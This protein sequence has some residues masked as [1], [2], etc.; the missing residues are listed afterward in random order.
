MPFLI[1]SRIVPASGLV[2][3]AV[4]SAVYRPGEPREFVLEPGDALI[5]YTD[6]LIGK[7][8]TTATFAGMFQADKGPTHSS[9]NGKT[10]KNTVR[11]TS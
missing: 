7:A 9:K 6:G 8:K 3:G 1:L 11:K 2:L 5:L 10:F 4:G